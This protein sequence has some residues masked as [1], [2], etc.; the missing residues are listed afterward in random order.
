MTVKELF[1][2][3]IQF[4]KIEV[5]ISTISTYVRKIETYILPKLA[6]YQLEELTT[7]IITS[8]I[9]ELMETLGSKS[10]VDIKT[11]LQSALT[12][13][14]NQKY[15]DCRIYIPA[16]PPIKKEIITFSNLEQKR[17]LKYIQ[18]DM[19]NSYFLVLL[20]LGT[21]MRIGELCALKYRDIKKICTIRYT[22]QR[23]K[24]LESD[25]PK[26]VLHKD[27]PKSPLSLRPVPLNHFILDNF[28]TIYDEK[29]DNCYILTGTMEYSEP[30]LLEKLYLKLLCDCHIEY[31][32]FH[33][34]RHTFASN[35]LMAGMDIKTLA[36]IMGI[37]VK[38][39]ISTYIHT[40]IEQKIKSMEKLKMT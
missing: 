23:I 9:S 1:E 37:S 2:V 29:L 36:E 32:K 34:L 33:T 39:L 22:V 19:N 18:T 20:G 30:R 14:F 10:V 27:S 31:K 5:K 12:F 7:T 28:R 21:G 26:T 13:A 35:A 24:N 4:K 17:L 3:W 25:S 40:N 15:V 38:V 16:P 6:P 11:I 8:F